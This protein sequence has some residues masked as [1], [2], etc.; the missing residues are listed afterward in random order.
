MAGLKQARAYCNNEVAFIAWEVEG[1]IPGCLGFELTRIYLNDDGTV[2][3]RNGVPDRIPCA[4]WVAFK[5][6]KNPHWLPQNTG[7]WPVQKLSWRDLTL[8][9]KR[10]GLKRRPDEVRVR[11]EVRAVGDLKPGMEPAPDPMPKN[12]TVTKR[13]ADGRPIRDENGHLVKVTIDAYEGKPRPLGYLGA[14]VQPTAS[15]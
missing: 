7:I 11:Y 1:S 10:D 14:P 4:S 15:S 9:K 13:D 6:Q 5:G 8:R 12:V 3:L 2:A